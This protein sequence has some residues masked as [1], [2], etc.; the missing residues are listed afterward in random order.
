MDS[1]RNSGT[2]SIDRVNI[3]ALLP[4]VVIVFS[5][6]HQNMR[7]IT[8]ICNDHYDRNDIKCTW[9]SFAALLRGDKTK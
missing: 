6:L 9:N 3:R 2:L 1:S 8:N 7:A 5:F 4:K